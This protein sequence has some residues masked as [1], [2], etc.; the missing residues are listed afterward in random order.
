MSGMA[1][2]EVGIPSGFSADISKLEGRNYK[3]VK[4]IE[5]ADRKIVIYLDEVSSLAHPLSFSCVVERSLSL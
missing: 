5:E 3:G 4:K 1:V 2:I